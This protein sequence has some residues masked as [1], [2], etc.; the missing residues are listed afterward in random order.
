MQSAVNN[1][2]AESGPIGTCIRYASRGDDAVLL[3]FLAPCTKSSPVPSLFS[4]VN[5]RARFYPL[6]FFSFFLFF[7][8]HDT[9]D[10]AQHEVSVQPFHS[11]H[12]R[13][14]F[15]FPSLVSRLTNRRSMPLSRRVIKTRQRALRSRLLSF[16]LENPSDACSQPQR[17]TY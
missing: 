2:V 17:N 6:F 15:S 7:L 16:C 1:F 11:P 5:K 8:N 13:R 3:P 9:F 12:P 14:L 4:I 10:S